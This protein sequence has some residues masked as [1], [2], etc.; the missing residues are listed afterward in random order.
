MSSLQLDKWLTTCNLKKKANPIP[1]EWLT[2]KLENNNT[3]EVL[4]LL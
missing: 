3:K 1:A 4:L 2:H